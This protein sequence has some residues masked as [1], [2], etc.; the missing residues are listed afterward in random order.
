[1]TR[2]TLLHVLERPTALGPAEVRE[3][4][5]LAQAFPYCQTAHLLLAKAAHDQGTMLAGQRLRRAATYAADRTLLRRLIEQEEPA[6][7]P[8]PVILPAPPH[9]LDL[10]DWPDEYVPPTT[11]PPVAPPLPVAV[12]APAPAEALPP[13][14]PPPAPAPPPPP[15]PV[16]DAPATVAETPAPP[17]VSAQPELVAVPEPV[18]APEPAPTAVAPPA[19]PV[20]P[21]LPAAALVSKAAAVEPIEAPAAILIAAAPAEITAA[22][23]AAE[24]VP[25]VAI[26]IPAVP[27]I[28]IPTAVNAEAAIIEVAAEEAIA[29][30]IIVVE[31]EPIP[32]APEAGAPVETEAHPASIAEAALPLAEPLPVTPAILDAAA[33]APAP[34]VLIASAVS[35]PV[36][37]EPEAEL[38]PQAPAIRP[39]VEVG[40]ARFE[41]GLADPAPA[42]AVPTY[43]LPGLID[44]WAASAVTRSLG[45]PDALAAAPPAPVAP[46]FT[47]AAFTGDAVVGYAFGESSRLGLSMQLLDLLAARAEVA[48]IASAVVAA[49][50]PPASALPPTG[51]FFEPDPLL[52][53]HWATHRPAAPELPSTV[54]LINNFLKRQPRLT[55][56]AMLPPSA[57]G[58]ADLSVR[59]TRAEPDLVSENLARIFVRQG[60]TARAIEIYEKLMVKQPE[61]MAYFALQ[62]QSLQPSA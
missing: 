25:E 16:A 33:A 20:A 8:E 36:V 42:P 58:Q 61:K 13:V 45:S 40:E 19:L 14:A 41:F 28:E 43:E 49:A 23:A 52:L 50:Q 62:I 56:P 34:A 32:V 2:A 57:G 12:A 44:E 10:V 31:T 38:P 24:T 22:P 30:E 26:I 6:A 60:K 53:D 59:S 39:P 4:E 9:P 51:T 29:A 21:E 1:M 37:A 46:V 7:A 5:Q 18:P 15:T 48:E 47:P 17:V 3:L 11:A 54:D 27:E 55:R 35:A